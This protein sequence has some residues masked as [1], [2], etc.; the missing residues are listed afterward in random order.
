MLS[1]QR[2]IEHKGNIF[3]KAGKEWLYSLKNPAIETYLTIMGKLEE[4]KL[5]K[6]HTRNIYIFSFSYIGRNGRCKQISR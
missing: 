3:T 1:C 4:A 5:L 2:G 6:K